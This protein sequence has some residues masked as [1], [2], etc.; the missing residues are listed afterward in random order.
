MC[1]VSTVTHNKKD[2]IAS[3]IS[4]TDREEENAYNQN[5]QI[6]DLNA[7]NAV[8]AVIKWKKMCG[9][10]ADEEGEHHSTNSTSMNLPDQQGSSAARTS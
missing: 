6:A 4:V 3:R 1:R 9:F 5:I 7:L 8:L 10:Y 2:H